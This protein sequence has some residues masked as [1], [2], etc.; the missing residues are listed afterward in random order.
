[1]EAIDSAW[2]VEAGVLG[3]FLTESPREAVDALRPRSADG[4]ALRERRA[5][6]SGCSDSAILLGRP[7]LASRPILL[8]RGAGVLSSTSLTGLILRE[9]GRL[10]WGGTYPGGNT[11]HPVQLPGLIVMPGLT[12]RG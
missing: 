8:C 5:G 4:A 7:R 9:L 12:R 11:F 10:A 2:F 1:M 3:S 6:A